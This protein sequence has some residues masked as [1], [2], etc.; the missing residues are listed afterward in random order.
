MLLI[1]L[2]VV[3][4]SRDEES[5]DLQIVGSINDITIN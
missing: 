1:Q 4:R 3:E 2:E 5:E